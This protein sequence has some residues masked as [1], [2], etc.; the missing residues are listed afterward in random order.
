MICVCV[1][2]FFVVP[3]T[4]TAPA[5]LLDLFDDHLLVQVLGFLDIRTLCTVAQTCTRLRELIATNEVLW[6]TVVQRQYPQVLLVRADAFARERS[7]RRMAV[8]RYTHGPFVDRGAAALEE[9]RTYTGVPRLG[10][11]Y[12]AET[13]EADR[14]VA[15]DAVRS[16]FERLRCINDLMPQFDAQLGRVVTALIADAAAAKEP[17]FDTGL[18]LAELAEFAFELDWARMKTPALLNDLCM[19]HRYAAAFGGIGTG[20]DDTALQRLMFFLA[21]PSPV[22]HHMREW[23]A[24]NPQRV[25]AAAPLGRLANAFVTAAISETHARCGEMANML[26]RLL[27]CG[28]TFSVLL[29][30]AALADKPDAFV[31]RCPINIAR[32]Q[33]LLRTHPDAQNPSMLGFL[34][35]HSLHVASVLKK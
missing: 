26:P 28:A 12:R 4:T 31:S 6:Q 2:A 24:A 33:E 13:S 11:A 35:F 3:M 17:S 10:D 29:Y 14:R 18:D 19:L 16:A 21:R 5:T 7:W 30:D 27:I 1:C 8:R 34:R 15:W 25:A 9:F 22:L 32:L 23:M 20:S